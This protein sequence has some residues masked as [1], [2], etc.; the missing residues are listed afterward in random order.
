M[1]RLFVGRLQDGTTEVDLRA[2]FAKYRCTSAEIAVDRWTRE[3]RGFGFVEIE[4][5]CRR[6]SGF[7]W[8]EN[9]RRAHRGETRDA[10][11]TVL[12]SANP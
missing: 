4:G 6:D 2:L 10:A 11:A 5:V 1:T 3:P 9:S 8:R 7:A 12:G